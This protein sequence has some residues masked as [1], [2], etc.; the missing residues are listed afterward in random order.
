MRD[1]HAREARAARK[2]RTRA[3]N[4]AQGVCR[5]YAETG[6]CAFGESC[7]FLHIDGARKRL[8]KMKSK[9]GQNKVCCKC[10]K[11]LEEGKT[12]VGE[13]GHKF[14]MACYQDT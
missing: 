6:Y 9:K 11:P 4:S 7:K 12:V 2:A 3:G 10:E 1:T 13:C 8:N 14:C 5:D